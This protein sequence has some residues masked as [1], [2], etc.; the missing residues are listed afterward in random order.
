MWRALRLHLLSL[1][2]LVASSIWIVWAL[3]D[4]LPPVRRHLILGLCAGYAAAWLFRL[5]LMVAQRRRP[6]RQWTTTRR[7]AF[8]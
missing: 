6:V 7:S 4:A 2:S 8:P 3:G 5:A 1:T